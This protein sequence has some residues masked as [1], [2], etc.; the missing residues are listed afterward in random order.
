MSKQKTACNPR[1]T[2]LQARS[3][4]SRTDVTDWIIVA[5][6]VLATVATFCRACFSDFN[7]WDDPVNVSK[8]PYFNPVTLKGVFYFWQHPHA[9][10]YIPL[11]D[12][13][14]GILAAIARL[15]APENGVWLNPWIFHTAN[16]LLHAACAVLAYQ[17]LRV[18]SGNKWAAC[19]GAL[20]FSVHPVQVESVAWIAGMRDVLSGAFC[21]ASLW[22]YVLYA[23]QPSRRV[24]YWIAT[25][26]DGQVNLAALL[27]Q[28]GQRAAAL[29]HA[30]E[31]LRLQPDSPKVRN[32]M[33][34][35]S[36]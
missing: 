2:R 12:T 31:A 16:V 35:L 32:L 26:V 15:D 27:A 23:R 20:L 10:V 13:V 18:I 22:Q 29:K 9:S 33:A 14:W 30:S 8:N 28:S 36:H 11:T 21:L 5:I 4:P 3:S 17:F 1:L 19:L 24:H 7:N 34:A 25:D 6:L